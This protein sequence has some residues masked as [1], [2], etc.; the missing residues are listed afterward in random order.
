MIELFFAELRRS[1]IQIIRY[2]FEATGGIFITTCLFYGLFLGAKYVAG[3][4]FQLGDRFDSVVIGYVLWALTL[5]IMSN[6]T[7]QLQNEAQTGTLEQVFLSLYGAVKVFFV[8]AIASLAIQLALVISI[9]I[10]ILSL[11]GSRLNFP[12]LLIFPLTTIILGA[13]GISFVMAALVLLFKRIGQVVNLSQFAFLF[14]L[15]TPSEAWTGWGQVWR[16]LVPMTGGAGL[17]RDLMARGENLNWWELSLA[18]VNGLVYLSIGLL[19]FRFSEIQTKKQGKL[20]G[21]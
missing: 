9:L 2:P 18:F 4:N 11:T 21:Y 19:V 6:T 17:L 10:I 12:P 14:V 16:W 8:R 20:G 3:P 5:F 13:Y 7:S 1:W 15:A